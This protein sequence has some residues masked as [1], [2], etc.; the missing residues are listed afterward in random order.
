MHSTRLGNVHVKL[1][2]LLRVRTEQPGRDEHLPGTV[3]FDLNLLDKG[4]ND[5][6]QRLGNDTQIEHHGESKL[7][8][9][10]LKQKTR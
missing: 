2:F 4:P 9:V 1:Y 8:R 3:G 6:H 5:V 7:F 10:V